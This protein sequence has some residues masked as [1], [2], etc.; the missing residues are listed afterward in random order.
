MNK[1]KRMNAALFWVCLVLMISGC[2]NGHAAKVQEDNTEH[3]ETSAESSEAREEHAETAMPETESEGQPEADDG[4]MSQE[5]DDGSTEELQYPYD[6]LDVD[7]PRAQEIIAAGWEDGFLTSI[8]IRGLVGYTPCSERYGGLAG[9]LKDREILIEKNVGKGVFQSD[10]LAVVKEDMAEMFMDIIRNRGDNAEDYQMFFSDSS[11][12][13]QLNAFLNNDIGEEWILLESF[14]L[15]EYAG[16]TW[17]SGAQ[18]T[19]YWGGLNSE[20][21]RS[22]ETESLYNFQFTFFADYRVM[23]YGEDDVAPIICISCAVSKESGLIEELGLNKWDISRND[24]ET[25]R[26]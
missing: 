10:K 26:W 6:Y 9:Y 3:A 12:L 7:D 4:Q 24:F 20:T 14:H 13:E 19:V 16:A 22:I 25:S 1:T 21:L 15:D 11:M 5:A 17:E 2:E 18:D 8:P 23:G